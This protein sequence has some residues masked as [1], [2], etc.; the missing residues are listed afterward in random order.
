MRLRFH[1]RIVVERAGPHKDHPRPVLGAGKQLASAGPAEKAHFSGRGLKGRKI[2]LPGDFKPFGFRDYKRGEGRARHLPAVGTVAIGKHERLAVEFKSDDA[3]ITAS[4]DHGLI[5]FTTCSEIHWGIAPITI[6]SRESIGLRFG[7]ATVV[8]GNILA[9]TDATNPEG[10]LANRPQVSR[11]GI[12]VSS[13]KGR[14][15]QGTEMLHCFNDIFLSFAY[16][17]PSSSILDTEELPIP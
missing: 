13:I 15:Y 3:A 2:L 7:D 12:K 5:S 8:I 6:F 17:S 9:K 11:D 14:K 1:A 16:R 10:R 4:F